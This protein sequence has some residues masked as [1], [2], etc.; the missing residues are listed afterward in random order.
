ML[1]IVQ[2]MLF[3]AAEKA[4][5]IRGFQKDFRWLS[6]FYPI[7][8][9]EYDGIS[10]SSVETFY[11]AMKTLEKSEREFISKLE[12]NKAKRYGSTYHNKNFVLR[13]DWDSIKLDVM[14]FGLRRK[15]SQEKFKNLLLLTRDIYIE[16]TNNWGDVFWGCLPSGEGSNHLGKIIMRIRQEL[17]EGK[18]ILE[19]KPERTQ[20]IKKKSPRP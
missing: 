2:E 15:F 13:E 4:E 19:F 18:N 1:E 7:D 3:E 14:E 12:P 17:Q 10:Y 8:P 9:F 11:V 5:E 20:A 16:E 6:N